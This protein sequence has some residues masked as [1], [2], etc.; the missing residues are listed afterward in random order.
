MLNN[1]RFV[2]TEKD[3]LVAKTQDRLATQVRNLGQIMRK[4]PELQSNSPELY[5]LAYL[6][7][8]ELTDS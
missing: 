6:K 8:F 2:T 5:M 7:E 4:H 3:K 1:L